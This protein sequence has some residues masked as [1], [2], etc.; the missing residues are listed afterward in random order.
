MVHDLNFLEQE[1]ASL[2][3]DLARLQAESEKSAPDLHRKNQQADVKFMNL[4]QK[5]LNLQEK[6]LNLQRQLFKLE[7]KIA[8]LTI[9]LAAAHHNQNPD[10]AVLLSELTSKVRSVE[11]K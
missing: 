1:N 11:E 7:H 2:R 4:R 10:L 6:N 3:E 5:N 8:A 9:E